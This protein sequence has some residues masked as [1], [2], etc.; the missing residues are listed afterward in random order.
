ML[1]CQN[2]TRWTPFAIAHPFAVASDEE[3][4]GG[5]CTGTPRPDGERWTA[6]TDTC[7]RHRPIGRAI[8]RPAVGKS[9]DDAGVAL[10]FWGGTIHE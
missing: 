2:C 9:G 4:A 10:V 8:A 7:P 6:H 1:T 3:R 5:F